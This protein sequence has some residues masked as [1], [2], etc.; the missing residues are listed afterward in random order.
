M[1]GAAKRNE[2]QA[3]MA[4]L[5]I[6]GTVAPGFEKAR[7]AFAANFA[8]GDAYQD[9]GASLS[10]HRAG[11]SVV[12]LWGGYRDAAGTVP[13]MRDTLINVWS[14]T[15]GIT[16][17]ALGMLADRKLIS[18]T[19]PVAKYW[20]EFAQNGKA[21]VTIAQMLSHQAGLPGFVEPTTLSDFYDWEAVCG[22][23]A[24]QAPMWEPGT[25]NSYH[26]M[27]Y[28]FLAGEVVRRVTMKSVGRFVHDEIAKPLGVDMFI[29]LDASEDRRVAEQIPPAGQVDLA[30]LGLPA[31]ALAALTNPALD[32]G[33]ANTRAWR[34]AEVP[35][36]NGHASA[37]A[38]SRIYGALADGGAVDGQRLISTE[39]IARMT[40]V[41]TGRADLLLGF[42]PCWAMGFATNK[43]G[44]YGPNPRSFGHSGWGGSFGCADPDAKIGIGFVMNRMGADLVGDP[45]AN[46]LCAAIFSCL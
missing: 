20:P 19:D 15:K 12:D 14:T 41:Q 3:A 44:V 16:A 5:R 24:R 29:G 32:A 6:E 46:G 34:A 45:R 11:R 30:A 8:R 10:V 22:R 26:A 28:G 18:Y 1:L 43:I 4:S 36:G 35:A 38:L 33:V 42:E 23:L 13:W 7:D 27:T 9:L 2:T 21:Q 39:G 37:A 25:K 17:L 40:E 31:E